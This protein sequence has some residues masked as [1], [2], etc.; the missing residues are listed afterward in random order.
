[1]RVGG[2]RSVVVEADDNLIP[3]VHTE[4]RDAV[5][6]IGTHGSFQ[7]AG[8]TRVLVT[9]PVL[10]G[11]R[12]TG[13]GAMDIEGIRAITFDVLLSGSGALT[14]SGSTRELTATVSGA[15]NALLD[16]LEA[17][18]VT[19][20]VSGTGKLEVRAAKSLDASV[21]GTGVISYSGHP[22]AVSKSVTG[23]GAIVER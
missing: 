2:D 16:A 1:V 14:V 11:V 3:L 12:L 6:E 18:N 9:V 5:L 20:L 17:E 10:G 23:V 13:S 15:G 7:T 19:A 4:V 8:E 21:T 22:D